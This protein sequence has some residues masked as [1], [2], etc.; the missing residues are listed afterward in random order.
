MSGQRVHIVQSHLCY[1]KT[2]AELS[3]DLTCKWFVAVSN[4]GWFCSTVL[5]S[6]FQLS[7]KYCGL[8]SLLQC[9]ICT[10]SVNGKHLRRSTGEEK[11]H[12]MSSE[13]T[14]VPYTMCWQKK[15]LSV[16]NCY[17]RFP[18]VNN[19]YCSRTLWKYFG[20]Y[21]YLNNVKAAWRLT[22]RHWRWHRWS[23]HHPWWWAPRPECLSSPS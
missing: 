14:P 1:C 21:C 18:V 15:H 6:C 9:E 13:C 23:L 2:I 20:S 3:D 11:S 16:K 7:H 5:N 12:R 8:Y 17:Q 22:C 19:A 4:A 10:P